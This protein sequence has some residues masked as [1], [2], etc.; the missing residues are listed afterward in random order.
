MQQNLIIKS[1]PDFQAA[2]Q[3]IKTSDDET[4]KQCFPFLQIASQVLIEHDCSKSLVSSKLALKILFMGDLSSQEFQSRYDLLMQHILD[5]LY[6]QNINLEKSVL[7][8]SD[9]T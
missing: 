7:E 8:K 6:M 5:A 9:L 1:D 4:L 2:Y 3:L